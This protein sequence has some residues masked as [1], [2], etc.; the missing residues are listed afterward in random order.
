VGG[1]TSASTAC[2]S[3]P[4]NTYTT[5]FA[6]TENPI[7]EG[8]VWTN[9]GAVGIDW[10]NPRKASGLA[11]A[12]NTSSGYNDCIAHLSGYPANQ[13][14]QGTVH[15][16]TGY[17]A[18]SSHEVELLL[19]FQITPRSARGYEIFF[20][21]NSTIQIVRW[22]GP[23]GSFTV[24]PGS[25]TGIISVKHGDVMRATIVGN[26]ISVYQNGTLVRTAT[27]STWANGNPGMGLFVR[28]GTGATPQHYCWSSFT[29]ASL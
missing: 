21:F 29:A 7:S 14:A 24:L 16:Q 18:P 22:N 19:R 28:P 25:G 10:Q 6:G 2:P 3:A 12:S 5:N 9:G 4:G 27:D 15:R 26:L 23:L 17:T 13:S 1:G 11:F 20:W 8:G